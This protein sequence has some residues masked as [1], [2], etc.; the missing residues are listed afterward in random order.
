MKLPNE[1]GNDDE[2][3]SQQS[4]INVVFDQTL[5]Y[6][7][8]DCVK[9]VTAHGLPFATFDHALMRQIF[10]KSQPKTSTFKEHKKHER[11]SSGESE[12]SAK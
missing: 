9:L 7:L 2:P 10:K 5:E 4:K 1:K 12:T 11:R 3:L 8:Q 6:I